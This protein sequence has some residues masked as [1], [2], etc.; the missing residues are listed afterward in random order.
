MSDG[1]KIQFGRYLVEW[2]I[3]LCSISKSL[4]SGEVEKFISVFNFIFSPLSWN[5]N[6]WCN[7]FDH[8]FEEFTLIMSTLAFTYVSSIFLD[9]RICL[10]YPQHAFVEGRQILDVVFI[11]NEVWFEVE[12][13]HKWGHFQVGY[14]EG[15]RSC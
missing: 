5:F 8:D 9:M 13:S 15:F 6:F 4:W 7:L 1:K 2:P 3:F 11:A 14:Q 10:W 12:E